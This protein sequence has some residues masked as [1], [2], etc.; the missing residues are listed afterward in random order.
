MRIV[1]A[2]KK[3]TEFGEECL[4]DPVAC[5]YTAI[6]YTDETKQRGDLP[7]NLCIFS[8]EADDIQPLHDAADV[9][10]ID[11]AKLASGDMTGFMQW[12]TT[13]GLGQDELAANAPSYNLKD[14]SL[15]QAMQAILNG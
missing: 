7:H 12:L 8:I 11:E 4:G 1:C 2:R 6:N 10:V 13:Q 3:Y 5:D 14:P 15:I 9:W